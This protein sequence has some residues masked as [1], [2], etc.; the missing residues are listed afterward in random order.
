MALSTNDSNGSKKY[1]SV[2]GGKISQKVT[3][4]TP[5]AVK[6]TNKNGVEIWELQFGSV[7]GIIRDIKLKEDANYGNQYEV[8]MQDADEH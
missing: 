1:L 2:V 8:S 6:R 3:A 4:D 7:S 5:G